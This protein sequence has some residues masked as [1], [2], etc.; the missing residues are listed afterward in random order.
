M[1]EQ[2]IESVI[3]RFR[4]LVTAN[5]DTIQQHVIIIKEKGYVWWAWWKKGHEAT[6]INELGGLSARAEESPINVFLIDSGQNKTYRAICSKINCTSESAKKSVEPDKTP[7]YYNDQ[8]YFA[9]FKFTK[10]EEC[11]NSELSNYSYLEVNSLFGG[12]ISDYRLFDNKRIFSTQELIQQNRSL[13]FIKSFKEGDAENEIVLLNSNYVQPHDFSEK[14]YEIKGNTLL[15]VSDLHFSENVFTDVSGLNKQTLTNHIKACKDLMEFEDISGLI[16]TGDITSFG[17]GSGFNQAKSFIQDLN[18]ELTDKLDSENIIFCPGNHDFARLDKDLDKDKL[19][20]WIYENKESTKAY[21]DFYK[22]I[23]KRHPNMY[24]SS[25]RKLLLQNGLTIEVVALNSLLLQQYKNFEG[26]GYISEE[27]LDYVAENMGW[28]KNCVSASIRIAIMHH[29]YLPTCFKEIVDISKPSSVVYDAD[30]LIQWLVKYN[31]RILL[32]GHKH[33]SFFSK[34][35]YPQNTKENI[36]YSDL[37]SL[38]VI[39]MGGTGAKGV[40]NKFGTITFKAGEIKV[41]FYKINSDNIAADSL[42]QSISIP[43]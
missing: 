38:A 36:E 27:Q 8:K 7:Q 22:D 23:Y 10:I 2:K 6:P 35:S 40:E 21:S 43:I 30:C 12:D 20:E 32:H 4:D 28:N 25:G 16:M 26:H 33:K 37:T 31:V 19:P 5:N 41:K 3:L 13:W 29:H 34:I 9:W 1:G 14:Y 18:R 39:G 42:E 11:E 17:D 24:F 15:W